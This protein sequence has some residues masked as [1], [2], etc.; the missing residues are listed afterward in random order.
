MCNIQQE[1]G[2]WHLRKGN[3]KYK[4]KGA[5][6][7]V[8]CFRDWYLEVC[9][10][11]GGNGRPRGWEKRMGWG[12]IERSPLCANLNSLDLQFGGQGAPK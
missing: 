5:W 1:K 9:D 7:D 6:R 11:V 8:T 3:R 10:R 4:Y 12:E 2:K